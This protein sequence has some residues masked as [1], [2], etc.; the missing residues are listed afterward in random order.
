MGYYID[1]TFLGI[2]NFKKL[3]FI[4][5]LLVKGSDHLCAAPVP[6]EAKYCVDLEELNKENC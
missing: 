3:F 6:R 2:K 4:D 1:E 5:T